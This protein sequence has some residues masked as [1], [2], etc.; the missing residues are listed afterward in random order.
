MDGV[1]ASIAGWIEGVNR[2]QKRA[3]PW[4]IFAVSDCPDGFLPFDD[5]EGPPVVALLGLRSNH[6]LLLIQLNLEFT[7]S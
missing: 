5:V 6:I 7:D 4:P 1:G 3:P 2:E